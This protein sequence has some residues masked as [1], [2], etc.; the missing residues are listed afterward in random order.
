MLLYKIINNMS[1]KSAEPNN[2]NRLKQ[3]VARD[4]R[5]LDEEYKR[6]VLLYEK[7]KTARSRSF[8]Q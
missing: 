8:Y 1:E 6:T 3:R 7:Q 4:L 5:K 2:R